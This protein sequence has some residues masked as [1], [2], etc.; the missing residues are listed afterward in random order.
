MKNKIQH[1]NMHVL[2]PTKHQ[3]TKMLLGAS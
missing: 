1:T 2:L 3:I